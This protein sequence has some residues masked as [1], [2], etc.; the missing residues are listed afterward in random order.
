MQYELV[1]IDEQLE[2][3]ESGDDWRAR[4]SLEGRFIVWAYWPM[5]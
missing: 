3:S 5:M 1:W 4:L 2:S